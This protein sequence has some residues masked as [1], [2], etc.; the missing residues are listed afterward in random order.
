MASYTDATETTKYGWSNL[1]IFT[2]KQLLLAT[3][4]DNCDLNLSCWVLE[5]FTM[6]ASYTCRICVSVYTEVIFPIRI[7][8]CLA[9]KNSFENLHVI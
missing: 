7:H 9:A 5:A 2:V 4:H 8:R 3:L 6:V 1:S